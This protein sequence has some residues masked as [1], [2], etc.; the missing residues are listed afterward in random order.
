M[1]LPDRI[2]IESPPSDDGFSENILAARTDILR[3]ATQ[4]TRT[5]LTVDKALVDEL[6]VDFNHIV[7][8]MGQ[9]PNSPDHADALAENLISFV[10]HGKATIAKLQ[11]EQE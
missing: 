10:D 5:E 1:S 6:I 2:W 4:Y 8:L 7:A 3:G 11:G 9:E